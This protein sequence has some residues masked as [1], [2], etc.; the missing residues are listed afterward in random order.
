MLPVCFA[1]AQIAVPAGGR[2]P[3]RAPLPPQ[4]V[5][6]QD[7]RF[8]AHP[9]FANAVWDAEVGDKVVAELDAYKGIVAEF[10]AVRE[11]AARAIYDL[12]EALR[13][14]GRV[15]EARVQYARLLREFVDFPDVTRL[16]SDR[17]VSLKSVATQQP[18]SRAPIE[19]PRPKAANR[20][21]T[22]PLQV[23]PAQQAPDLP[24]PALK[25]LEMAKRKSAEI[26][27]LDSEIES[28]RS[29]LEKEGQQ[30][31]RTRSL[32]DLIG[33]VANPAT[34]S[35]ELINDERFVSKKR[36]YEDE[37]LAEKPDDAGTKAA[38][39]RL[40]LWIRQVY[41]PELETSLSFSE[42]QLDMNQRKLDDTEA[43]KRLLEKTEGTSP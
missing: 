42:R 8:P 7:P 3:A 1:Q 2:A 5:P 43:R 10:D 16:A 27:E 35:T 15:E 22:A 37:L 25:A 6:V 41:I 13:V 4:A 17:L 33:S 28:M 38:L 30:A 39:D 29:K 31:Q 12:G 9:D 20:G 23:A 40:S 19:A 11:P 14:L 21:N 18:P 32:L 34:I 36:Q 24:A 26:A